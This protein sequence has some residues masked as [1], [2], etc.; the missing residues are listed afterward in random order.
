MRLLAPLLLAVALPC[1]AQAQDEAEYPAREVLAAF[2]TACSGVED[3]A[4]NLASAAAAGW[5]RL[6][7][8]A[9]TPVSELSRRGRAALE[10][11]AV[12]EHE[13]MEQLPGGEF[14]KAVA[15]RTLYL[16]ISGARME[17]LS[18]H[19][20]R[21]YDFDAPR[22]LTAAELEDWAA[23]APNEVQ[24]L[25]GGIAKATFSPGLKPG[26]IQME[27]YFVPA[28]ANPMPGFDLRGVSLVASAIVSA[29]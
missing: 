15:G 25:P 26:H 13:P 6:P 7:E 16:A 17:G 28:G 5:D 3:N 14:R 19:G 4:V 23:R 11:S 21:V 10:A 27:A 18:S 20:C 22:A 12:A 8:D 9:E 29:P 1:V 2:A 24:E